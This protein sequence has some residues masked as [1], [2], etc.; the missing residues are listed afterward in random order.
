MIWQ[1]NVTQI[2]MLTNLK[3]GRKVDDIYFMLESRIIK[4]L[5]FCS[6]Y[7]ILMRYIMFL[8]SSWHLSYQMKIL[9]IMSA[10]FIKHPINQCSLF[11]SWST[12][13]TRKKKQRKPQKINNKQTKIKTKNNNLNKQNNSYNLLITI[14]H[15]QLKCT[16]YW[17]EKMKSRLHGK[18]VINNVEEK[19]YAFYVIR[20]FTVS[21]REVFFL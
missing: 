5:L 3:E 19:E 8:Y 2:V 15:Y 6:R 10:V 7:W 12:A 18:I 9:I 13:D 16:Q 17:P 11:L 21:L 1:E 4:G 14:I 20:K